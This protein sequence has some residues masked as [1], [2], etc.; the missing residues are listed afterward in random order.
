M[1]AVML[2][3]ESGNHDGLNLAASA[4]QGCDIK[5]PYWRGNE[6]CR[7]S[8][9]ASRGRLCFS[10]AGVARPLRRAVA[11][12]AGRVCQQF[13]YEFAARASRRDNPGGD[14]FATPIYSELPEV[15]S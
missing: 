2:V 15:V 8:Y 11:D 12:V 6:A 10:R 9:V 14:D 13:D 5:A 4:A 7:L 3:K 1:F